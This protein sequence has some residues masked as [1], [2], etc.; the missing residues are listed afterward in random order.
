[1]YFE[2]T[3]VYNDKSGFLNINQLAILFWD[4]TTMVRLLNITT[5][6][7]GTEKFVWELCS[8]QLCFHKG[9]ALFSLKNITVYPQYPLY[10]LFYTSMSLHFKFL[11][12]PLRVTVSSRSRGI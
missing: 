2:G 11:K 3:G 4:A 1:M 9:A 10:S 12:I 7:E 8:L 6:A 5:D